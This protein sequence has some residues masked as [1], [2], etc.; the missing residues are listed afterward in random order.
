MRGKI[1]TA[2]LAVAALAFAVAG[3]MA[4]PSYALTTNLVPNPSFETSHLP[5][6][7]VRD[8]LF[9]Q[10][11][12]PVGWLAEGATELFD[13]TPNAHYHG[14]YSAGISGSWSGP[15]QV[16]ETP[17]C[18][19]VAPQRDALVQAYSLAPSWRTQDPIPVTPGAYTFSAR[20]KLT[21]PKDKT[22]AVT[23]VRWL[24]AMGVPIG[25]S[26]GPTLYAGALGSTYTNF[27]K[28]ATYDGTGPKNFPEQTTLWTYRVATV[29]APAG[30]AGAILL[31]S[32]SDD[33]WNGSV[34][35]DFV[36]FT[37][38]PSTSTSD[39]CKTTYAA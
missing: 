14:Q 2:R 38:T 11:V 15:R 1:G 3:V 17:P 9:N 36:C 12:L 21:I 24:D 16:C 29:T 22:G 37:R 31:L 18:T 34:N 10:P 8:Y 5:S 6:N 23:R 4:L 39:V 20:I 13:H 26:T 7:V 35:Y 19:E 32:Y 27:V 28:D 33:M 30:A 25:V